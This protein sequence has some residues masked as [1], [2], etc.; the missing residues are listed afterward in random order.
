VPAGFTACAPG[1]GGKRI[2][3]RG[4]WETIELNGKI[5]KNTCDLA[6]DLLRA[7]TRTLQS[8]GE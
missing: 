1:R 3:D 4:F 5:L 2:Y 7:K 6:N 8:A